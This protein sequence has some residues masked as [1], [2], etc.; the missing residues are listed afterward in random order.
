MSQVTPTRSR[1]SEQTRARLATAVAAALVMLAF[2]AGG[3][4]LAVGGGAAESAQPADTGKARF[5]GYEA[6]IAAVI[7]ARQRA[8]NPDESRVAA[9]IAGK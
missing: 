8:T 7:K 5:Q 2:V 3:L 4:A 9:A 1:A 6:G